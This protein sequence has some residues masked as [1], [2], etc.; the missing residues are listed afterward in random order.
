MIP[1]TKLEDAQKAMAV[2]AKL[3]PILDTTGCPDCPIITTGQLI[4]L[5]WNMKFLTQAEIPFFCQEG[6]AQI[7]YV[8]VMNGLRRDMEACQRMLLSRQQS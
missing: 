3:K 2:V 8:Y 6:I 1:A 7:A 5:Y 4:D